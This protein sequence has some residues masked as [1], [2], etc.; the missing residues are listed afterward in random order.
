VTKKKAGRAGHT[1]W[2]W[3]KAEFTRFVLT[4]ERL[5]AAVADLET[6]LQEPKRRAERAAATRKAKAAAAPALAELARL[7]APRDASTLPVPAAPDAGQGD[8]S[9]EHGGNCNG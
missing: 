7:Q 4:V 6:I 3:S 8:G 1:V 2:F 5:C 9:L